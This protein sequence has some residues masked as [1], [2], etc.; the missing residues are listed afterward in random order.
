M[1][2]NDAA[3]KLAEGPL[4]RKKSRFLEKMGDSGG[5]GPVKPKLGLNQ[6]YGWYRSSTNG[7]HT[8]RNL[9]PTTDALTGWRAQVPNGPGPDSLPSK[10]T[11]VVCLLRVLQ[12]LC[13]GLT[14]FCFYCSLLLHPHAHTQEHL[15]T[16]IH[17]KCMTDRVLT[18]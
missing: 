2:N 11:P 18:D 15:D 9:L 16:H 12:V 8:P 1:C 4:P 17:S 10:V 5:H 6:G 7:I 3:A 13:L 14:H